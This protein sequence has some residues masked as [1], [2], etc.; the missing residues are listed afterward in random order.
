M[1]LRTRWQMQP[2][3]MAACAIL[4]LVL[5]LCAIAG[6]NAFSLANG[7]PHSGLQRLVAHR[8]LAAEKQAR[9]AAK[10]V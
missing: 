5:I 1:K 3:V 7:L 4:G 2:K 8:E 6:G 10:A 9:R